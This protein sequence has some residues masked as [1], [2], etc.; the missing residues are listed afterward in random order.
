MPESKEIHKYVGLKRP[1]IF[2]HRGSS[3]Y[4][5]EN[6]LAAFRL[7]V[8]QGADGI[9]LDAKLCL[10]GHVVVI[11]DDTL[12]RTTNGTGP[13]KSLSLSELKRVDAGSKFNT[14]YQS[15]KIPSLA[16]VFE[17]IGQ[18]LII[19]VELSNYSSPVDDLPEK[20]VSLIKEYGLENN[21]ML[22]SFNFIALIRA[23]FLL[24]EIPLGLITFA[25]FAG[26][27]LSSQLMNFG[28][29]LA[30]H[31][32]YLDV[33]PDLITMAHQSKCR[34]HAYTVNKPDIMKTLFTAGVDGIFTYDP[35]LAQKVLLEINSETQ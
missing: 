12:D 29:L 13:V 26:P 9:E 16:E 20:V 34:L 19:N 30:L 32:N 11:H 24:P 3:A 33:T 2:A 8:Q 1:T 23:H 31:P 28:P 15:E 7:A 10:D 4:A 35:L 18:Q 27:F 22:S 6:T 17:A 21:V 5:P 14:N 25:G